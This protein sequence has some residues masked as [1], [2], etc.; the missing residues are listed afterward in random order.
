MNSFEEYINQNT[1]TEQDIRII[2]LKSFKGIAPQH[3]RS[4]INITPNLIKITLLFNK[5]HPTKEILLGVKDKIITEIQNKVNS[6]VEINMKS[7]P[8]T[9]NDPYSVDTDEAKFH[10][11]K[12]RQ[13]NI[14]NSIKWLKRQGYNAVEDNLKYGII[15]PAKEI[16]IAYDIIKRFLPDTRIIKFKNEI[17]FR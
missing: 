1:I 13:T 8:N 9:I 3:K 7:F 5:H 12:A 10:M 17:L 16:D 14:V 2:I 15:L 11:K 6:Q 4:I